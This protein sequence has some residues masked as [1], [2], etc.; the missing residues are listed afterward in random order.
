MIKCTAYSLK[1]PR[2]SG[3]TNWA[4]ARIGRSDQVMPADKE[5]IEILQQV[6]QRLAEDKKNGDKIL[7][8]PHSLPFVENFHD[9]IV[10]KLQEG[11]QAKQGSVHVGVA[12]LFNLDMIAARR[13]EGAVMCDINPLQEALW[14][15]VGISLHWSENRQD[16]INNISSYLPAFGQPPSR[17]SDTGANQYNAEQIKDYLQKELD[18]P[19]SWL[20]SEESFQHVKHLFDDHKAGFYNLRPDQAMSKH[21]TLPHTL[22]SMNLHVDTLYPS[23]VAHAPDG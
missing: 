4:L 22:D 2:L 10:G 16:F 13:S 6:N 8:P 9:E 19:A 20:H 21:M 14:E 15:L 12:G 18:R 23:N 7:A 17:F 11:G 5:R 3:N 1:S